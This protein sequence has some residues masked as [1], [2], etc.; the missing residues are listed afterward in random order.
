M[1]EYQPRVAQD[2]WA[3]A[4]RGEFIALGRTLRRAR[5][6]RDLSQEAVA[7]RAGIGPKHMSELERGNKNPRVQTFLCIAA[8]LGI[9]GAELMALYEQQLEAG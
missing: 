3:M 2:F 6:D 9:T 4:G 7:R 1:V 5:R 8:A